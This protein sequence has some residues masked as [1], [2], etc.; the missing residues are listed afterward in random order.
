MLTEKNPSYFYDT[1]DFAHLLSLEDHWEIIQKEVIELL[2]TKDSGQWLS[3]FPDYVNSNTPSAWEVYTF[4]FFN[5]D[6]IPNRVQCKQTSDLITQIPELISCD[7]SI[8]KPKTHIKAHTG[9]S[10]LILR[11]HLPLIVPSGDLCQ[12]R[13]GDEI[14]TWKEGELLI[15]DDSHEHEAWNNSDEIRVVLM[16]DIPNPLWKYSAHE[17]S[18]YK[19][20]HIED[21]FLLQFANKARWQ[22]GFE[23]GILPISNFSI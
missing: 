16:F 15:F 19:I 6:N 17:I 7:F 18:K 11:C 5:M 12:I 14:R 22:E 3:T 13:V 10:K 1:K 4:Q 21:P 9:Y 8:I 2:K 20:D 23:K